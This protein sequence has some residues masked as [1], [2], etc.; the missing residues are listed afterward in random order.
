MG[1]QR[2]SKGSGRR[3]YVYWDP[4]DWTA[5]L[6]DLAKQVRRTGRFYFI[7]NPERNNDNS[8]GYNRDVIEKFL[9]LGGKPLVA[10][11]TVRFD[12]SCAD[13]LAATIN[14]VENRS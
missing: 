9:Q 14:P 7:P 10:R 2:V 12:L 1:V 4:D 3:R 11:S 13:F 6:D 8:Y 5:F